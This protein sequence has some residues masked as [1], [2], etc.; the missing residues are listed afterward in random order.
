MDG[1]RL[2]TRD[3]TQFHFGL[4]IAGAW[5]VVRDMDWACSY[6]DSLWLIGSVLAVY[7]LGVPLLFKYF[8]LGTLQ[9]KTLE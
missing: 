8:S 7:A 4:G 6:G 5:Q 9:T 2:R 1:S 3:D